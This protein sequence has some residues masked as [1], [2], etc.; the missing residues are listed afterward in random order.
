MATATEAKGKRKKSFFN[1]FLD[2]I[3]RYGN[4]LPDPVMLFV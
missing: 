2:F 1:R 3:E 4:K